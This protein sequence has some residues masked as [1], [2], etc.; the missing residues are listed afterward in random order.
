MLMCTTHF[1]CSPLSH[2]YSYWIQMKG[3]TRVLLL[4]SLIY[5][6]TGRCLSWRAVNNIRHRHIQQNRNR[7]LEVSF[8]HCFTSDDQRIRRL[9]SMKQQFCYRSSLNKTMI[10]EWLQPDSKW[11]ISA[12]LL[13][14]L[15]AEIKDW[16]EM[17]KIVDWRSAHLIHQPS[18]HKSMHTRT[19]SCVFDTHRKLLELEHYH[20]KHFSHEVIDHSH[21]SESQ[22]HNCD[23]FTFDVGYGPWM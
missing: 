9:S 15:V 13:P 3:S 10:N 14:V 18:M 7:R 20:S 11:F 22:F 12:V 5:K 21:H 17:G 4:T 8:S 2:E 19:G 6:S 23:P 16:N 1:E